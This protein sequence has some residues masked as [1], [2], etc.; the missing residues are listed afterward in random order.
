MVPPHDDAMES[1]AGIGDPEQACVFYRDHN[2]SCK[3]NDNHAF[4]VITTFHV[5]AKKASAK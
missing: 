1:G 4:F 5:I 2:F 3:R